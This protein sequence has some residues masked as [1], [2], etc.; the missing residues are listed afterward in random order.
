MPAAK[1]RL[2]EITKE[3]AL[4]E[5]E[6]LPLPDS[7]WRRRMAELA[8]GCAGSFAG[9]QDSLLR[10]LRVLLCAAPRASLAA[11]LRV[12]T[13]DRLDD[14]IAVGAGECALLAMFE[15][16][17]G[18]L[19]SRGAGGQHL[20]SVALPGCEDEVTA[21]GETLVLALV[22]ALA[23]ALSERAEDLS[24]GRISQPAGLRLN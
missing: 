24:H 17:G 22:G 1:C 18:Y 6:D 16:D 14:L 7:L 20:A 15:N 5:Y 23:L 2:H 21:G 12:P 13:S 3:G 9:E 8:L 19:I 4:D 10:E 11:G